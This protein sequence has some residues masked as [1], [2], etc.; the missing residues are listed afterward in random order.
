MKS[1]SAALFLSLAL[2]S[3]G[4]ARHRT[5]VLR[6]RGPAPRAVVLAHVHGPHC[7]HVWNG[8][9]WVVVKVRH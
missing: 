9:A 4:C 5:V 3:A 8:H 2:F 1:L 7:G 6:A